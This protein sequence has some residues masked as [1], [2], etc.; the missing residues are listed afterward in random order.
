MKILNEFLRPPDLS[1]R[2]LRYH[3]LLAGSS[4]VPTTIYTGFFIYFYII[5]AHILLPAIAI[6]V[7]SYIV[8]WIIPIFYR[9]YVFAV[10]LGTGIG[11][12]I[13][14]YLT[15]QFGWQVGFQFHL[16]PPI[17]FAGGVFVGNHKSKYAIAC[18]G[19]A[20]FALLAYLAY[21]LPAND[22]L[23][24]GHGVVL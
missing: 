10:F 20:S 11:I 9:K 22:Q 2:D 3:T 18:I 8:L 24:E 13:N 6:A 23:P 5:G 17:I 7:V 4:F 12:F 16:I 1:E 19:S 14:Y 15:F 21:G